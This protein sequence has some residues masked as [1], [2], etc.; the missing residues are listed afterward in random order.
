MWQSPGIYSDVD[1]DDHGID[2]WQYCTRYFHSV[3]VSNQQIVYISSTY[4]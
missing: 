3:P 1:Y 2:D 4:P